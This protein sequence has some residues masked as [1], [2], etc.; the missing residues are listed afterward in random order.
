MIERLIAVGN[1]I[2]QMITFTCETGTF[3][4]DQPHIDLVREILDRLERRFETYT[5]VVTFSDEH[6]K[7]LHLGHVSFEAHLEDAASGAKT[8]VPGFR[9]D[10]YLIPDDDEYQR[11]MGN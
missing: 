1:E 5:T 7:A 11:L 6:S 9:S 3:Y 4:P 8:P 10:V 2:N